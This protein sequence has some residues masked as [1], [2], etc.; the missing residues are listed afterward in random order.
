MRLEAF[1][2]IPPGCAFA[3]DL[4]KGVLAQAETPEQLAQTLILVPTRRAQ[5][6]L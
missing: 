4:A 5:R 1:Y 3:R 6:A 2:T